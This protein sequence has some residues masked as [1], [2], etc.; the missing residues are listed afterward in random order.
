MRRAAQLALDQRT[1]LLIYAA[2]AVVVSIQRGVFGFPN[3]FAIFRASFWNLVAHRD[4]YVLRLQQAHDYFKYSPS[5]ALLFGPFAILPFVVGLFLWNLVNALAIF[6]ALRLVLP[7]QQWAIAQVLVSLP[8]LRS[9]QSAQSNALV[10]ALIILAFVSFDRDW[11]GRGGFAVA[12]G[13]VIKIFPLAA[14]TFAL[15]RPNRAR[16]VLTTAGATLILIALPL[17]VISP[18]A[19]GAQYQSWMA[20]ER[21]EANLVGDSTLQLLRDAGFN[22]PLWTVQLIGVAVV[23]SVLAYRMRDWNDPKLRLRFL[24]FV[25]VFCVVFN[26]RAERQSAVIAVTGMVTWYLASSRAA[27][28]TAF[29]AI[30]YAL[31]SLSGSVI[32]P[33]AIKHALTPELRFSIPLTILWLVML[34]ELTIIPKEPLPIAEAV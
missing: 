11:L 19:L 24:G 18:R 28:R 13:A 30:V 2:A 4:L 29:F 8:A 12:L 7:R 31:V 21:I 23:L 33:D 25:M 6:F 3:D 27:W 20:L 1:L 9:M 5:F 10:T 16:A 26:H 15:P 22:F 14:I 17:I 32:V 34:C